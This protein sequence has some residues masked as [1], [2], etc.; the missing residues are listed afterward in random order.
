MRMI[1]QT[2]TSWNILELVGGFNPFEKYE[3]KWEFSPDRDENKKYL[4]PPPSESI[5]QPEAS[6]FSREKNLWQVG[7]VILMTWHAIDQGI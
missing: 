2:Q 3:S 6:I 5:A 4:K 7:H 1:D